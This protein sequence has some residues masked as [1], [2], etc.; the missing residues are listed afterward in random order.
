MPLL[1]DELHLLLALQQIDKQIYQAETAL[2]GLNTGATL[3]KTYREQ[4]VGVEIARA[5]A[6]K[7][8]ANQ[9]DFEMQ[10][11]SVATKIEETNKK[12]YG[13]GVT[14]SKE[15]SYLQAE[16]EAL[17]RQKKDLERK[18]VGATSDN[19]AAQHAF[20]TVNTAL[21][22]IAAEYRTVRATY[23][24]RAA[25]LEKEIKSCQPKRKKAAAEIKN[26]NLLA[27]YDRLRAKKLGIGIAVIQTDNTCGACH[28]RL[29]SGISL[30]TRGGLGIVTCET[31][32]RI[33]TH[34]H[35]AE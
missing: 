22:A 21:Q 2:G 28:T 9:H 7:T 16:V 23:K 26:P 11:A 34:P 19:E 13:G 35:A 15:L 31:C 8:Q 20:N 29:S 17:E 25:A 12:L 30:D 14:A 6:I 18:L 3:A 10:I 33:L 32:A 5:A 27:M 24:T 1:N 4:E